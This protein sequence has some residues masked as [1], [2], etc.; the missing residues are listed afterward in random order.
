MQEL[1]PAREYV[2]GEQIKHVAAPILEEY[3]PAAHGL[4]DVWPAGEDVP[5]GHFTGEE[6]PKEHIYP[7]GQRVGILDPAA[8]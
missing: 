5:I 1:A 2:P 6:D 7:A 3:V 8:V 4:H